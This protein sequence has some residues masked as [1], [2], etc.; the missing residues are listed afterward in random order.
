MTPVTSTARALF[1]AAALPF[2]PFRPFPADF[3]LFFTA[4]L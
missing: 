2:F 3:F 1:F 4:G